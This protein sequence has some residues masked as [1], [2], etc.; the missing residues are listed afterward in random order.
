MTCVLSTSAEAKLFPFP[1]PPTL[2]NIAL[3]GRAGAGKSTVAEI[4]TEHYGYR[5]LSFAAPL[6]EIAVTLW[7]E[8]TGRERRVLQKLGLALRGIDPDVWVNELCADVD[9]FSAFPHHAPMVVDDLRFPNEY[10][11][12]G[13]RGFVIVRVECPEDIR[14]VRL[15]DNGKWQNREQLEHE[16]EVALDGCVVHHIIPNDTNDLTILK[17]DVVS[18]IE[19]LTL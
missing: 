14:I 2:P 17:K 15:K 9:L 8:R 6:K 3:C 16:T 19:T 5:Q 7:G 11:A 13:N 4:L 1:V 12:L 10:R 18:L